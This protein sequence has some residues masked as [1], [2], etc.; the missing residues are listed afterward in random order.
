MHHEWESS[1]LWV[2]EQDAIA[3]RTWDKVWACR[4]SKAPLLERERGGETDSHRNL[5]VHGHMLSKLG[6][7]WC[8]LQVARSDLLWLQETGFL[9]CG[10]QVA[11][12]I[13]CGSGA[14]GGS[15]SDGE[16]LV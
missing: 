16:P 10:V 7:L 8:R 12:H 5:P 6:L 3:E 11:R 1:V 4:R 15:K 2:G 13:W 14:V 9:L